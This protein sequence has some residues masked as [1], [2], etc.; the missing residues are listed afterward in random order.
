MKKNKQK[1]WIYVVS[2]ILILA[3]FYTL[4]SDFEPKI[5]EISISQVA[6]DV[7]NEKVEGIIVE[8][9]DITVKFKDGA[10][11]TSQIS[12]G[13][14]ITTTLI[15]LGADPTTVKLDIR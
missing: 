11:K 4:F 12:S 6:E 5:D 7:K 9:N 1:N 13:Q 10:E 15:D 2:F 3:L 14:Q 8:G